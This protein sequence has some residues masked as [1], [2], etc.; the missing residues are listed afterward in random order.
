[1]W[2]P[3]GASIRTH[4][5]CSLGLALFSSPTKADSGKEQLTGES[6]EDEEEDEEE[7]E[8]EFKP[9]DGSENE[10]E[11]EILNYV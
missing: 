8:E 10:M 6:G 9:S 11:T 2:G 3:P 5:A 4:P 7:E 1:M